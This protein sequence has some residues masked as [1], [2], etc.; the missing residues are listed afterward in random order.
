MFVDFPQGSTIVQPCAILFISFTNYFYIKLAT[1]YPLIF[2][3]SL[4]FELI[5][6][7]FFLQP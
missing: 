6:L 5:T 4:Y 7:F 3:Q 1:A 2:T